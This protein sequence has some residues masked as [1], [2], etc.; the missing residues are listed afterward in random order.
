MY[1]GVCVGRLWVCEY[2]YGMCW[3]ESEGVYDESLSVCVSV[4]LCVCDGGVYVLSVCAYITTGIYIVST[5][6]G[7]LISLRL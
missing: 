4:C 5:L 2:G 3:S 1:L 7:L 6:P